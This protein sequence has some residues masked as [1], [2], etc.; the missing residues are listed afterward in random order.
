[1]GK[2]CNCIFWVIKIAL[3]G[4]Q[5]RA[6]KCAAFF[7]SNKSHMYFLSRA[8]FYSPSH[9][10]AADRDQPLA[11]TISLKGMLGQHLM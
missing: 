8:P 2:K 6:G 9:L 7:L 4:D 5:L 1:M 10:S 11:E 3:I